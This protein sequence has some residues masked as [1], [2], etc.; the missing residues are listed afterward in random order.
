MINIDIICIH[1]DILLRKILLT[2]AFIFQM[3]LLIAIFEKRS[4]FDKSKINCSITRT[5][6]FQKH[7]GFQTTVSNTVTDVTELLEH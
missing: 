2:E 3:S 4:H 7:F 6:T 1:L 5:K